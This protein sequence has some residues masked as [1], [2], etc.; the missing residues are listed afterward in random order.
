MIFGTWVS[1]KILKIESMRSAA[2]I[3]YFLTHSPTAA[4]FDILLDK[5]ISSNKQFEMKDKQFERLDAIDYRE[6]K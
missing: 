4:M 2:E 1:E 5:L 6:L 3:G